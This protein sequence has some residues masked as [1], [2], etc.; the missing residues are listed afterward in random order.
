[1]RDV[2]KRR[3]IF[4]LANKDIPSRA[5]AFST[6]ADVDYLVTPVRRSDLEIQAAGRIRRYLYHII[7][8]WNGVNNTYSF[9]Y[10]SVFSVEGDWSVG[11]WL[12]CSNIKIDRPADS[13]ANI[14]AISTHDHSVFLHTS[15][16]GVHT[17]YIHQMADSSTQRACNLIAK[18]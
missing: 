2:L 11:V 18:A 3:M 16:A 12:Q 1:M 9:T 8:A 7:F 17:G 13:V 15:G 5:P 4:S 10:V 6:A 14:R